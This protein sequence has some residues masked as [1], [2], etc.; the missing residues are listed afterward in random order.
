MAQLIRHGRF[1]AAV[2]FVYIGASKRNVPVARELLT[3]RPGLAGAL[4]WLVP[5]VMMHR[6]CLALSTLLLLSAI[7]QVTRAAVRR[8]ESRLEK[9]APGTEW[10]LGHGQRTDS[11]RRVVL[12]KTF[13]QHHQGDWSA[14]IDGPAAGLWRA[15]GS[16]I[17][18]GAAATDSSAI[19]QQT[20][21]D[22]WRANREL[23]P[24]GIDPIDL[25]TIAN[26][27]AGMTRFVSAEQLVAGIPVL[28]S[29]AFVAIERG[30]L[31]MFGARLF[32]SSKVQLDRSSEPEQA[33]AVAA[34]WL[35]EQGVQATAG[36]ARL[37][38]MPVVGR[39]VTLRPV[40]QVE[41]RAPGRG[42]WTAYVDAGTGEL[43]AV[44]DERVFM[45]GNVRI[46]HHE[47][48]PLSPLVTSD[49]PYLGV[50][51]AAGSGFTDTVGAFSDGSATTALDLSL[52]GR[53]ALIK[54]LAGDGLTK[55][56]DAV[57]DHQT[58][59]WQAD[60]SEF[61]QAQ[62]DAYR[63]VSTVRD[64]A[65]TIAPDVGWL[66]ELLT[67]NV[68]YDESCNAWFDGELT[69]LR[70]GTYAGETCNNSAMIADIVYHEFGHGLHAAS[71]IPGV[72][73]FDESTSEGFGDFLAASITGDNRLAP[74]LSD[75]TYLRDLDNLRV[76]PDDQSDDP[77]ETGLIVAGALWDLRNLLIE[78]LG[79]PAG[80]AVINQIFVGVL[81]TTTDVPSLY[82][83]A[84]LADDD[85]GNLAD[86]T[87]HLCAI[88]AA[89]RP[90][91]LTDSR[92]GVLT[93]DH[94]PLANVVAP[95]SP[96]A[97]TAKVSVTRPECGGRVGPVRL[98]Y[99]L[100]AGASWQ[101]V[102]MVNGAD[103]V[104]HAELP[105]LSRG[106]QLFYRIEADEPETRAMLARPS[107]PAAPFFQSYVGELKQIL[108]DDFETDDAGYTHALISGSAAEGADDWQRGTPS[109]KGDDPD[110]AYSGDNVWG[111]DI[112]ADANWNG[113]YQPDKKNALSSPIFDLTGHGQVRL[114]FR[115]WLAVEDGRYDHARVFVNDQQVWANQASDGN[116][117]H[118]DS[119]WVLVD[120]DVS[121]LVAQQP[122][123]QFRWE[124]ESDQG[125]EFGG[126]NIDDV[127]LYDVVQPAPASN[128]EVRPDAEP[129]L[130]GG[131]GCGQAGGIAVG[132]GVLAMAIVLAFARRRSGAF[133]V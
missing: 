51:T 131:C 89:F 8:D 71:V 2:D 125:K 126:W 93:I 65:K 114:Q 61:Q 10:L 123:L 102:P 109:G 56:V 103:D 48:D 97:I 25:R 42:R 37:A 95:D 22:F 1:H 27:R 45:T 60:G 17:E 86:G 9:V 49:G 96:I 59:L 43:I 46:E 76:W 31:V 119:E 90:H 129:V 111:N 128:D 11:G 21:S 34:R 82:E 64:Y 5:E 101:N 54:N 66:D 33:R 98:V 13:V 30:R 84:L 38:L 4:R 7:P 85:N 115:R 122:Q 79:E 75:G 19:A 47:R 3:T 83:S 132:N 28:G 100:D 44:R 67:V 74:N 41:L 6:L 104:Q 130:G 91:G 15:S 36:P 32:A 118:V 40:Q 70:A 124:L 53:F 112:T 88:E 63:F 57:T 14:R 12:P 106:T 127:C 52:H 105:A 113:L 116:L 23:L 69:F 62:L 87:P 20:A 121:D 73:A 16:G 92:R 80:L 39:A 81:R 117:H 58:V 35:S 24:A 72:G 78:Q 50:T 133:R 107:N 120:L 18:V 108:C 26:Q 77:H 94:T 110:R 29:S 68:N 99:S 55:R